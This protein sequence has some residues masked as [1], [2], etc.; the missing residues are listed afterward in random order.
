MG[1]TQSTEASLVVWTLYLA[2]LRVG[3]QALIAGRAVAI[4]GVPPAFRHAPEVVFMKELAC[5]PLFAEATKPVLTYG[6]QSLTL[7]R[8]C[9][10]LL[11]GLEVLH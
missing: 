9:R 4:L 1:L 7:T 11:W 6:G 8:V 5:V 2:L 10:K 3:V